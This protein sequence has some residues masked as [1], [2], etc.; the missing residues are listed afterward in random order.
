[1]TQPQTQ[2]QNISS[3]VL[4]A[5]YQQ[6]VDVYQQLLL[7]LALTAFTDLV[8]YQPCE[9]KYLIGLASTLHALEQYRYALVFYGYASLLDARDAG[10]TVTFR[11][12]QCYPGNRAN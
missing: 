11:I 12:A 10:V 1:M 9:R 2:Q 8:M 7:S 4:N 3:E 6:A 5:T